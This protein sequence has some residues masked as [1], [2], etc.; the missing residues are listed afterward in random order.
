MTMRDALG[1]EVD[2]LIRIIVAIGLTVLNMILSDI[3]QAQADEVER[4]PASPPF[5]PK[6]S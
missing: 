3:K 6:A 5:R 1:S 2:D 4:Q